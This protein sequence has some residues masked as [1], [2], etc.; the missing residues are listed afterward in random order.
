MTRQ[1]AV[2]KIAK[3]TRFVG[4]MKYQLDMD[5]EI[6]FEAL[7][8]EWRHI[9]VW[10]KEACQYLGQDASPQL[11]R[12]V[13]NIGYTDIVEEYVQGH[14]QE[15]EAPYAEILD[16]YVENMRA[17][18]LLCD[19]RSEE[20][21]GKYGDLIEPLANE[22]IATLLQRAVNAGILDS[23]YQPTPQAKPLQLKVVAFAV[24]SLGRLS[25]P[26]VL[27][28][29]QWHR[30]NGR[31]FSTS[32][33]PKRDT[34]CYETAKALYP[35][36]DFSE[37]EPVHETETFYTPQG[38]EDRKVMYGELVKYGYI[39][40]DTDFE[41]FDGIFDKAKF[42]RPVEWIKG[43]R[44]LS[45]FVYLA[46]GKFNR[47]NL[48]IKAE[49]CF[50]INGNVP[51]K[52]C[53][54]SGYSWIKRAGWLDKYDLRLKAI[55]SGFNHAEQAE[56]PEDAAGGRAIHTSKVVFHSTRGEEAKHAMYSALIAG[57]YIDENTTFAIFEG[58]FDET[59][60]SLPVTWMKTQSQ[61]MYFVHLA[62]KAENPFD[63]W[64]KCVHCFRLQD[65]KKPN[66]QSMDSNY[67][68]IVKKG[69]MDTYDA[70]L[71]S[72]ADNYTCVKKKDTKVSGVMEAGNNNS[73]L[74]R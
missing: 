9:D 52:A 72:I 69:R 26:Y 36:V 10:T 1:E 53:C 58:I 74:T 2:I 40:P 34:S 55:C 19:T 39:A 6:E 30:E 71:K 64:V 12:L 67:R 32:R 27:F 37:F 66:R 18:A 14:R 50:R 22:R 15:I 16:R 29:K 8:P 70:E 33:I 24:S 23:H 28:E 65:G 38:E 57:G 25:S 21:K 56:L 20:R 4:E 49:C 42:T 11:V 41:V 51:H 13:A 45:Y 62:F 44:Q 3:I 63:V 59:A 60:F 48:W 43:Q 5:D 17:L 54:V 47:K 73:I 35:E 46:F 7:D 68:F 61:L 31:R